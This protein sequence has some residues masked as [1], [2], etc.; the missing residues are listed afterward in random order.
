MTRSQ[1][2]WLGLGCRGLSPLTYCWLT[3][4]FPRSGYRSIE[5][6]AQTILAAQRLPDP[7]IVYDSADKKGNRYAAN[8]FEALGFYREVTAD[9]A[10]NLHPCVATRR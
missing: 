1:P 2:G 10:T 5:V 8:G 9:A 4:A 6:V 3:D 7:Q